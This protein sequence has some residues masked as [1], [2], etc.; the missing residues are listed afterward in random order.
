MSEHKAPSIET[1]RK[2]VKQSSS[3]NTLTDDLRRFARQADDIRFN[4]W[5][6]AMR[7]A[8]ETIDSKYGT[9]ECEGCADRDDRINQLETALRLAADEP[10]IDKARA[11]ADAALKEVG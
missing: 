5:G 9:E 11:I 8:A 4:S 1:A 6:N 2:M 7:L 10:N 3:S